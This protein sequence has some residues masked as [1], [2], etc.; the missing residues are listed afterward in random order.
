MREYGGVTDRRG[1]SQRSLRRGRCVASLVC[2]PC[3]LLE[4]QREEQYHLRSWVERHC[5][6]VD[7]HGHLAVSPCGVSQDWTTLHR[8]PFLV[9]R[10]AED[11]NLESHYTPFDQPG[12]SSSGGQ[13]TL[14]QLSGHWFCGHSMTK[15]LSAPL[16]S[17]QSRWER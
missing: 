7:R 3:L 2:V 13:V 9:H 17:K 5:P 11:W 4:D 12:A 8:N 16:L 10:G 1:H 14:S 15:D 6:I